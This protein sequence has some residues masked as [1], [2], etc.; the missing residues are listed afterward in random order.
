MEG[1]LERGEATGE[2][3]IGLG[4][5]AERLREKGKGGDSLALSLS[6]RR[7]K[8]MRKVRGREAYDGRIW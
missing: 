1:Q 2:E 4:G 8:R 3:W 7:L 6:A 5:R